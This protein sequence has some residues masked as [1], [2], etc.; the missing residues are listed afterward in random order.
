MTGFQDQ[1]WKFIFWNECHTFP[2]SMEAYDYIA[3]KATEKS[4]SLYQYL[5]TMVAADREK[6]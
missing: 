4:I 1:S 6:K 2:A 5:D 3:K